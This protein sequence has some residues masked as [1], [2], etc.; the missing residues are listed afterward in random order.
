MH[1]SK[2]FLAFLILAALFLPVLAHAEEPYPGYGYEPTQDEHLG[3]KKYSPAVT[4]LQVTS[5]SHVRHTRAAFSPP[6]LGRR[7]A[8]HRKPEQDGYTC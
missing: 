2:S 7:A 6:R 1:N 3:A 5:T 8:G 4:S